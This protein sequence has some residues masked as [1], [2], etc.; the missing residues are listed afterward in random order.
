LELDLHDR[1]EGVSDLVSGVLYDLLSVDPTTTVGGVRADNVVDKFVAQKY[2]SEIDIALSSGATLDSTGAANSY[3][4]STANTVLIGQSN[5]GAIQ[6]GDGD[7][8]IF[9][10]QTVT[11]GNGSNI[12]VGE[13]G[14]ETI[15]VG[16]GDNVIIGSGQGNKINIEG[17]QPNTDPS[18]N[19]PNGIN[20]VSAG[21]G[22]GAVNFDDGT[23]QM[24]FMILPVSNF[25]PD[26]LLD[27]NQQA[28]TATLNHQ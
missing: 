25:S 22:G 2:P 24:G 8:L 18:A 11:V 9:G 23:G 12:I 13:A 15:T 6:A 5:N 1:P 28:L 7:N 3:N 16:G 4:N 19:A 14:G 20:F 17:R 21:D 27:L 26:T 10:G